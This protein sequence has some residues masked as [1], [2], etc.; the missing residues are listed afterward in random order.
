MNRVF[1]F[2]AGP[3]TLP[4]PVL[5]QVQQ[6]LLNFNGV[7]ASVIE[8]SHR[9][10]TFELLLNETIELFKELVSL[11]DNYKVL[12]AHG[13]ARMQFSAVPMNLI[14]RSESKTSGFIDTGNWTFLAEQDARRYGKT[15]IVASGQD[16]NFSAIPSLTEEDIPQD[17]SYLHIC[18]NNTLYG[19]RWTKYPKTGDVPLVVDAT[20]DILSTVVDFSQFGVVFAGLQKNL[21]PSGLAL[22]AVRED[23]IGHAIDQTPPLLDYQTLS[24]TNSLLNTTNTFAIYVTNLVLKWVKEQGGVPAMQKLNEAKAAKLYNYLE[25]TEFYKSVAKAEDRSIMNVPFV[26]ANEELLATFLTQA[27]AEGLY[28]LKG[29]KKVGGVRASIYNAMPIAGVEALL[30]FMKDFEEKYG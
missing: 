17:L 19:T 27:E 13:S 7:G 24:E 29:H 10:P 5:E 25:K 21:G 22:T 18:S 30:A 20:S 8:I 15:S 28:A 9:S 1:N 6:E 11:P 4:L 14:A 26:L 2:G 16:S 23:L 3:A 12:F